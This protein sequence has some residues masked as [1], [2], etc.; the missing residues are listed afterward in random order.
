MMKTIYSNLSVL[1]V[2][3]P[4]MLN[5]QTAQ[6][7]PLTEVVVTAEL[8]EDNV[9]QLPNSVT[10]ISDELI[11][12]RS[13]QHL[14]DLLNLAPNV[15]F[16]TGAARGRFLQIRGIGERSEFQ[17]PIINSVG[18]VVDG[19]DL[20]GIGTVASTLDVQ[21]VEILR[22]PQGT[23]FG[24]NALA[25]LVNVV[26]NKPS[27]EFSGRVTAAVE[28]FGG[29]ELSGVI[30]G[31]S[32]ANSAYR[33]AVK[34]YE[35]DGFTEDVFLGRDDTNNI[36]ETTARAR[37]V[38]QLND[39]LSLDATLFLA[40][41]RNGYDAFSLDNTRQTYSDEPGVDEVETVAGSIRLDY[42]INDSL[43]F[44]GLLSLADSE[45]EYRFDEDW[46][47]TGICDNTACDSDL[48]GFD[49]FYS[50][51]DNYQRDNRNTS[52]D[53][54]LVSSASENTGWVAGLYLRDQSVDLLREY[55][56]NDGDFISELDTVNA[57]LYG[58]ANISLNQQW[59]ITA[60][61]RFE[62]RDVDYLDNTGA[63]ANTSEGLWGGRLALEYQADNGAF[64]YGLISRG[65]KPGGFNL[66]GSISADRR[67]FDT[68]TMLNFELGLKNSYLNDTL[69]LQAAVFYQDRDDIQS[70]Q[71]IVAS[72]ATGEL[73]GQCPCSFTDFTDNAAS[74][75]NMGLELELNWLASDQL[76]LYGSIGLLDTE[77]DT[78]LT[79]DHVG[80]DRDNGIPFDLDGREQAHA[81]GYQWVIGGSYALS[82]RL[83]LSGSIEAKDDFLFS[84][85]HEERSDAYELV[86]LEISYAT[87]SW[88]VA[89]YGKNLTDELVKTRGFG[90][91][92]NDP[93][94]F[95]E[96]EPYNQ[97]AAP[98]VV[99]IKASVDF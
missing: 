56:F 52:V 27:E 63:T 57:A 34:H 99:G 94:K 26:S 58:Q 69:L 85:R 65:Y 20:T 77:F 60:G 50:S 53:L 92:G 68:E 83:T 19:I 12:Q 6:A 21:Q 35:S 88:E 66:D 25:G 74:G 49:W 78:L 46:S 39:Q 16:A 44:E 7:E 15:N 41:I 13:A 11:Q 9:L 75:S 5:L 96:T 24:A 62:D 48:F 1:A 8:L 71:S 98:R 54:R 38:H 72:L 2:L 31:P 45:L 82:E 91:F 22:G 40:D 67:E 51:V 42:A 90:S 84:D 80:A 59:S 18:I 86:N 37:Y 76:S 36:D 29:M 73:G 4:G 47:H 10:V 33:L 97:F 89:I 95:Y 87:E 23:L 43:H 61:L 70:K 3:L 30:S 14:E 28:E 93:R 17:E 55:T 79:F 81:P 64:Y 32:S